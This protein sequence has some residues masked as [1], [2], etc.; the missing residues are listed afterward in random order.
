MTA[1]FLLLLLLLLGAQAVAPL[2]CQGDPISWC[3]DVAMATRCG[4]EQQCRDLWDSLALGNVADGDSVAQGRGIKCS[5]CTKVLK[6]LKKLAGDDPDEAAVAAALQKGC[7]LLGRVMGKVCQQLVNK[8]QDQITEGL[9]NGD[10]PRDIC[11]AM[12]FCQS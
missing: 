5:Q 8:Y 6:R 12:G 10:M 11:S 7:R 4:W 2:P 1:N 9:Q 3:W